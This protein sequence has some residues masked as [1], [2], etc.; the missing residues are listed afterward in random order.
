MFG[1]ENVKQSV[2][3]PFRRFLRSLAHSLTLS[4]RF[5]SFSSQSIGF[6]VLQCRHPEIKWAQREDK[7]YITVLLADTKDEKVNLAPEGVFT[8]SASAGQ[9]EYDLKLEL[10]DK[11]NV[12]AWRV[13]KVLR[14]LYDLQLFSLKKTTM[15]ALRQLR[16]IA[17]EASKTSLISTSSDSCDCS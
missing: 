3:S 8:L 1:L 9:H 2:G 10:F 15:M 11:V 13:P 4:Y 12:E 5:C 16:Q 14:P 17:L 6:S 7:F